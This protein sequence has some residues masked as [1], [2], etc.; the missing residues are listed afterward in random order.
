MSICLS[1]GCCLFL[2]KKKQARL[3]ISWQ[4]TTAATHCSGRH[5]LQPVVN[6]TQLPRPGLRLSCKPGGNGPV[7]QT[8]LY[9]RQRGRDALLR[10]PCLQS[11]ESE[12]YKQKQ[13]YVK[14]YFI[15]NR[16]MWTQTNQIQNTSKLMAPERV[17]TDCI[18]TKCFTRRVICLICS[19]SDGEGAGG[20]TNSF[21]HWP[22]VPCHLLP[23][24]T[25]SLCLSPSPRV[26][27][28]TRRIVLFD[29]LRS[30]S[31]TEMQTQKTRTH[32][33]AHPRQSLASW[34]ILF[35]RLHVNLMWQPW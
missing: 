30:L 17:F 14:T 32:M 24:I 22:L 18:L 28:W 10:L 11:F 9:R 16:A 15:Q 25:P 8:E 4:R 13:F 6:R 21:T 31:V 1:T 19:F 27:S 33:P 34:Q 7:K 29:D 12:N 5:C 35:Q 23:P 2:L 3:W 26:Q 20:D